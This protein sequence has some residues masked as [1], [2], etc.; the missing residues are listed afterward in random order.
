MLLLTTVH[1]LVVLLLSLDC[2]NSLVIYS[3]KYFLSFYK[4]HQVPPILQPSLLYV[5]GLVKVMLW[6]AKRYDLLHIPSPLSSVRRQQL[7]TEA[8]GLE[9]RPEQESEL[10][11]GCGGL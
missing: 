10:V 6:G 4:S 2:E 3:V 9:F 5:H 11:P 7:S 8:G 1:F